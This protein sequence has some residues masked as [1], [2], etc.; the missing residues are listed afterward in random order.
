M[1]G[2]LL[3]LAVILAALQYKLW[4]SDVGKS[5]ERT[6]A[7]E[8]D[9]QRAQRDALDQ[10]NAVL[11]AEVLALKRDPGALEARARRDLGMIKQGEVFYFVPEANGESGSDSA[12]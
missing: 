2:W 5:A 7:R 10:R 1:K 6:L 12:P 9:E 11:E 8:L 3:L 4:F